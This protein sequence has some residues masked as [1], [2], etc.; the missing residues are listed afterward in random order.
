VIPDPASR[1]RLPAPGLY[2]RAEPDYSG[3]VTVPVL[4]DKERGT[5]ASNESAE[6]IR[7]FNSAFD[8]VGALPG[9]YYPEACA[10]RSTR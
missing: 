8:G 9:D 4:W 5:I 2:W 6:I 1:R 3:R 7:M 10:P